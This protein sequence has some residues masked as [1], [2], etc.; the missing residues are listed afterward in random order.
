MRY[1]VITPKSYNIIRQRHL[2]ECLWSM[3]GTTLRGV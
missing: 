3:R 2:H 1:L